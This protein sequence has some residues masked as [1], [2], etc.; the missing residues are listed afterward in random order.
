[1]IHEV[2]L[3]IV[4]HSDCLLEYFLILAAGCAAAVLITSQGTTVVTAGTRQAA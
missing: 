3:E 4:D 1:V 2:F